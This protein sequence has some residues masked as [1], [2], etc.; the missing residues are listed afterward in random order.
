VITAK[1]LPYESLHNHS[2]LSDG[3]LSPLDL[4]AAA[5]RQKVGLIAFT[6][7]DI[8]PNQKTLRE[9]K[10]YTGP[11]KWT[12]GIELTSKAA[13]ESGS[14]GTFHMLGLFVNPLNK[15]L[16]EYSAH[17][18][19]S[20]VKRMRHFVKHLQSIGFDITETE[21]LAAAGESPVGSPHIVL[22]V[23]AKPSNQRRMQEIMDEMKQAATTNPEIKFRYERMLQEGEKTH[24][25]VLFMKKSS[26]I[27]MPPS[28]SADTLLDLDASAKLIRQAGGVTFFAHWFFQ[29]NVVPADQLSQLIKDG[30]LD[31][32]E[33]DVKN[34]ITPRDVSKQTKFLEGLVK[35]HGCLEVVSAD[36]HNEADLE[37]FGKSQA[38]EKS[39]G[40]TERL[41]KELKPSLEW[42]NIEL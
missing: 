13:R 11:V 34:L 1:Q 33:T 32:V 21:C 6:E 9:L 42:S 40:Q 35:Q 31:G 26:F 38:G 30:R 29:M 39:I 22:A 18:V 19:E 37:Y 7:H 17:V 5:E 41:I 8:L 36:A 2:L 23:L 10:D 16:L 15:E 3:E 4:L 14:A 24:P 27:S 20:R 28:P 12:V 25:Y